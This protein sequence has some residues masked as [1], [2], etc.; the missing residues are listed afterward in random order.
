M[1][2]P[3]SPFWSAKPLPLHAFVH[4]RNVNFPAPLSKSKGR[5][6]LPLNHSES[7]EGQWGEEGALY[8]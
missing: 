3:P 7:H 8:F 2:N 6:P 4:G 5:M 1:I